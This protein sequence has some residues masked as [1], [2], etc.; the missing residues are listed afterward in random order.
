MRKLIGLVV[1]VMTV[2]I[3]LSAAVISDIRIDGNI[4]KTKEKTI[5]HIIRFEEG[6]EIT[7]SDE[8]TIRQ[9]LIESGLFVNDEIRVDLGIQGDEAELSLFL[10]DRFSLVPIPIFTTGGGSP[11]GGLFLA[12]Q[13][14]LGTGNQIF[15]GGMFGESY[16]YASASYMDMNIGGGPWDMGG[17]FSYYQNE[18][19]ITSVDGEDDLYVYDVRSLYGGVTVRWSGE[20]WSTGVRLDIGSSDYE[21]TEGWIL[22]YQPEMNVGYRNLYHGRYMSE[23]YELEAGYAFTRYADEFDISH[24]L[25][26]D[27]KAQ[28]LLGDRIQA[29]LRLEGFRFDGEDILSPAL[30]SRVLDTDVHGDSNL[31]AGAQ[32]NTVLFDFSWAYI[33]LPLSYQIGWLEGVSTD[34]EIYHGP[35]AGLTLNLKEVAIPAVSLYYGYNVETS[36]GVTSFSIGMSY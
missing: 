6:D 36:K 2:S 28:T 3:P 29:E 5:L 12:D 25:V 30:S 11:R 22:F 33:A 23:G 16:R 10:R 18:Q 21:G 14:F 31:Q 34:D 7:P 32:L 24:L 27:A 4:R 35:A 20:S 1:L 17:R 8:E 15:A 19:S 13:N 9:R 26:F